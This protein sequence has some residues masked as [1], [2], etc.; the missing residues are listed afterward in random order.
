MRFN[1]ISNFK[2]ILVAG[3]V[4]V[5]ISSPT[6]KAQEYTYNHPGSEAFDEFV[7]VYRDTAEYVAPSVVDI[8]KDALTDSH[9]VVTNKF[10]RNWYAYAVGA[11]HTFI[12]DFSNAGPFK[13]TLSPEFAIGVGKWFT[14]GLALK[15][16]FTLSD[17]RGYTRYEPNYGYGDMHH[18]PNGEPYWDMK[19]KWWDLSINAVFNLSRLIRGYEGINNRKLMNQFMLSAGVGITHV[20]G[21]KGDYGSDNR[22]SAHAELQ[23]SRFFTPSKRFSLDFK[24][25]GMF[26]ETTLDR[27]HGW[28]TN[29]S[30]KIDCNIGVGVGF[31][32]YI[33]KKYPNAWEQSTTELHQVDYRDREILIVKKQD[34][35]VSKAEPGTM[36]FYVF[37][38]NNYSGRNDAPI[39][40]ES[41][42]NTMD[43][44]AGGL[45]TQKK[46][47][48]TGSATSRIEA[49][50]TLNGLATEDIPTELA[51]NLTFA[52]YLPR[53]YEISDVDPMSLSLNPDAMA[54]FEQKEGF[55]YAPIYDGKHVWQYR[56]DDA[57][58]GQTLLS[59]ENYAETKTYGLNAHK[60]LGIIQ[61][62][63]EVPEG[64]ELVSF[65]D[66]YAAINGNDGY[67]ANFTDEATVNRIK[68]ILENGIITVVE[69]E[70]MATSQDNYT[71][72]N[73]KQIGIERNS[74][75]SENRANSVIKWMQENENLAQALY[76]SVF[77]PGNNSIN[78]V[79][80]ESTRGLDAKLNRGVKVRIHYVK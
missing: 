72:A 17:S 3:I 18:R 19:Y 37:Y 64:D 8:D 28:D 66:F 57:T 61:E 29:T 42:V 39:V 32:W 7:E 67:I 80:D 10:G 31:T 74:A 48:D 33:G 38:P 43:Y 56:I 68:D 55:Y 71:G 62:N 14:P 22:V 4:T 2:S 52:E 13:G 30:R 35:E 73:A 25:R 9:R 49:G 69:T 58:Q 36:T 53:G 47:A 54:E 50:R 70:G 21:F 1:N 24:I 16:E 40:E 59:D 45:F 20:Y 79:E 76:Q 51:E 23:Y 12:G 15:A 77:S 26:Y 27:T 75:L 46:Y 6:V 65:A 34:V 78:L 11:V 5:A 63:M 60:G 41:D 44:L